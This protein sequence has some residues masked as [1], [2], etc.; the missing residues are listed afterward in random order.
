[1]HRSRVCHFVIDVSDLSE[2]VTRY[3]YAIR[4]HLSTA[5]KHRASVLTVLR[6]AHTGTPWTPPIPDPP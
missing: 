3:R 4:G 2:Q 5:A 1:M 6:D